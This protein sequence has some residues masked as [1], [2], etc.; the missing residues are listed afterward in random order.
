MARPLDELDEL[1]VVR[2]PARVDERTKDL[3]TRLRPGDVAIIDHLDLDRVAA[4]ALLEARPAAVV[5]AADSISG[6]YPNVG[7]LLIVAAGIPLVDGVGA[8][9]MERAREGDEVTVHGADVVVGDWRAAGRRQSIATLEER[10]EA[11]K[12]SMGEELERFAVNTLD[13]MRREQHLLLDEPDVPDVGIDMRGRHV[14]VV[15]RGHDYKDDLAALRQ[16]GYL[17]DM[18]PV[19]IAVD[20]AADA[21][22][23]LGRRPDVIIGDMDSVSERALRCGAKV[24]VHAYRGGKAP[25]AQRLDELGV[26][27]LLYEAPGTSEDIAMLLAYENGAQL[28]VAVGTHN[29]MVEFLDKGRPGM[30][31]TFLVR[32][33]VGPILVDAK[34]V[35]KLYEGRVRKRD[36]FLLVGSAVAALVVVTA[37]SQPARLF[38]EQLW[39]LAR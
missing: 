3:A 24:V 15:V 29:S 1:D 34:G 37:I 27:Y 11:A 14:L 38:L 13:Y 2:G 8:E 9:I 5:N 26:P 30:A 4:E 20:G 28:I 6:R 16:G 12:A 36:L 17:A 39:L 19:L 18:R 31:S 32:L 22:L 33:K 7:P 21:L 35:N 23:D 25:G 10:I